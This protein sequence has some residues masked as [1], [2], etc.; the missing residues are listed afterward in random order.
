M[1]T[2]LDT[3]KTSFMTTSSNDDSDGLLNSETRIFEKERTRRLVILFCR[4]SDT[5]FLLETIFEMW[6]IVVRVADS[7]EQFQT[8]LRSESPDAI[9]IDLGIPFTEHLKL[10]RRIRREILPPEVSIIG[11]SGFAKP[12]YREAAIACGATEYLVKP[13]DYDQLKTCLS[14][15]LGLE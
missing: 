3:R 10:I 2:V 7:V 1:Q 5:R 13:L 4:E 6:N 11:I 9:V 8:V 14:E 15:R 12:A